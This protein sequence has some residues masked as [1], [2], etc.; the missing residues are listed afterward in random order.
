MKRDSNH[1]LME[2]SKLSA[3][4]ISVESFNNN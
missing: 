1:I 4:V 2:L 3:G